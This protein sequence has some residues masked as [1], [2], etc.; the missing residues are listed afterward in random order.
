MDKTTGI[1]KHSFFGQTSVETL[2]RVYKEVK[3]VQTLNI[4]SLHS[5]VF[6]GDAIP[7]IAEG[8]LFRIATDTHS[9]V[10]GISTRYGPIMLKVIGKHEVEVFMNHRLEPWLARKKRDLD[11]S[12]MG[13]Y[14]AVMQFI[15][16]KDEKENIE[17]L[18]IGQ[19]LEA[20][21]EV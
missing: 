1:V 13:R 8:E 15:G 20:S 5:L 21:T 7:H 6:N 9:N 3:E 10:L 19:M 16:M 12:L 4:E 18:N 11:L 14:N 2:R 17:F